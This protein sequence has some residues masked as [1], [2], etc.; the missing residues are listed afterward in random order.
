MSTLNSEG[1]ELAPM[2]PQLSC[3]S[4]N[5]ASYQ[6]FASS[7]ATG[8][9]ATAA[10]SSSVG[11][12]VL[13]NGLQAQQHAGPVA[14]NS[15]QLPGA[16]HSGLASQSF[17]STGAGGLVGGG[18][19]SGSGTAGGPG[20]VA[21]SVE[22]QAAYSEGSK[23]GNAFARMLVGLRPAGGPGYGHG[24]ELLEDA[25][26]RDRSTTTSYGSALTSNAFGPSETKAISF[27][28]MSASS[29][30]GRHSSIEGSSATKLRGVT[31]ALMHRF[32]QF[33]RSTSGAG[34]PAA[35]AVAHHPSMKVLRLS[36]RIG[37]A[38]GLLPYGVDVSNSAVACRAKGEG[39]VCSGHQL[40]GQKSRQLHHEAC[41]AAAP[42]VLC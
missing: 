22:L 33:A 29:V 3:P 34:M 15:S 31:S 1:S 20:S 17:T 16:L 35:S 11:Q 32:S 12:L 39:G 10:K 14:H 4:T 7:A 19:L 40:A 21:G 36:V 42:A 30:S 9:G 41:S 5:S 18:A 13:P 23:T 26:V 37:I 24:N 25:V 28:L 38:T 8:G 2:A 6:S 27:G